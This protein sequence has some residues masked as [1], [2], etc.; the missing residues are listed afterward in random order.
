MPA[1]Q[2][3]SLLL[4]RYGAAVSK[5][6]Q[7]HRGDETTYGRIALPGGILN[8][9]AK[10]E[11]VY[12]DVHKDGANKGHVYMRGVGV[13]YEPESVETENGTVVTKGQQTSIFQACYATGQ[14]DKARSMDDN[15][16]AIMNE[17]R[18]LGA[19][20]RE[21]DAGDLEAF[22]EALSEQKPF[23]RFTTEQGKKT[24]QYPTPRVFENWHGIKGVEDYAPA[25]E[26]PFQDDT[27]AGVD[28][29]VAVEPAPAPKA[30]PRPTP[31][32]A[33][34]ATPAAKPAPKPKPAPTPEPEPEEDLDAV[35]ES[36]NGG[37]PEGIRVLN[38]KALALGWTQA[39]IDDAPS[40]LDVGE[41]VKNGTTP[42]AEPAADEAT[43]TAAEP[44]EEE[45]YAVGNMFKYKPTD[46][47]T[48]KP[49][50][51]I[52]CEIM[53]VDFKTK[54]AD[55]KNYVDKKTVYKAVPLTDLIG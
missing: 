1:G 44:T 19:E 38:E 22:A 27:V 5:A 32:P 55:L 2:A 40:W 33:K 21:A 7:T 54:K 29:P 8:G 39:Q 47:K 23:F 46:P 18:K 4:S 50:K 51:A 37:D 10:L 41:W 43:D 49:G 6:V 36:A 48:K 28:E 11:K 26:I 13:V 45:I 24:P 30:A 15:I 34:A 42:D 25:E 3:K 9:V 17:L 35:I 52:D 31:T 14:G 12:F 53:K 20:T 16:A